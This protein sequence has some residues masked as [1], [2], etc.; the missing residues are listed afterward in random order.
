MAGGAETALYGIEMVF[1]LFEVVNIPYHGSAE[2]YQH[3]KQY[4]NRV[5]L[6]SF[7]YMFSIQIS[8]LCISAY[9]R[10]PDSRT[11]SGG[12]CVL[13]APIRELLYIL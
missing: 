4:I 5:Y 11:L 7:T 6:R 10:L 3:K 13:Y 2:Y 9:T 12:V 8:A 1:L